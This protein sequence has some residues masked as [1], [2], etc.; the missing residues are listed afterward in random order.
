MEFAR[1]VRWPVEYCGTEALEPRHLLAGNPLITEFMASNGGVLADGDGQS[2]DWIEI[3]NAADRTIDLA[4]YRLTDT[5]RD[6]QR[7]VFPSVRLE[8][9]QYLV[10]FA[11]SQDTP[12]YLDAAGHLHTDF[13]LASDGEYVALVSPEGV[14]LSEYAADGQRYPPQ[15]TNVSYGVAQ[16]G[17]AVGAKVGYMVA[18]SPGGP[19]SQSPQVFS[20]FVVGTQFEIPHGLFDEP[21]QLAIT[22]DPPE[23]TIRYTTDGSIPTTDHGYLYEDPILVSGTTT[24]RAAAFQPDRIPS[25]VDT[26]TYIFPRDVLG[27][28]PRGEPPPGFPAGPVRTQQLDYGMDPDIVDDPIWGPLLIQALSDIPTISIVTDAAQLF[29]SRTG[30][31]V[32]AAADGPEWERPVSVELIRPDGV[33]GF[34]IDAGLR[35]RGGYSRAGI[36]PKHAFRLF[37]RNQYGGDLRYPLF[38]AEGVD[39]FEKIDLRTTQNY[40]WAF[41]GD[42]RNTFLR[43]VLS[44]D[45]QGEMGQPYTR[46]RYYHLYLNGQYWGLYQTQERSEA[47]YAASY[48]GGDEQDYDVIKVEASGE[49]RAV[50]TDGDMRA[51]ERLHQAAVRGF[52]D[53]AD[54]YR[55]QGLN[56][57]GTRDPQLERLLDADNLIDYMIVTY[58]TGDSDGP[59]SRFTR[60]APNNFFGVINRQAPDGFKWLEHDSE[61]SFNT[62]QRNMVR[63]LVTEDP[64]FD[65]ARLE[66]FNP[67]WLHEVLMQ[68]AEYALHFADRVQYHFFHDGAL[69]EARVLDLLDQRAR[70]IRW[71]IV[72]ESAR[73]G[74]AQREPALTQD[75]WLHAVEAVRQF[76]TGSSGPRTAEVIGQLRETGYFPTLDAP[77]VQPYGGVAGPSLAVALSA[78]AG[79]V[80]YTTDGSDPRLP[81]GGISTAATLYVGPLAWGNWAGTISAGPATGP[82]VGAGSGP[83]PAAIRP[84]FAHH[85]DQLPPPR[86]TWPPAWTS[87][88]RRRTGSSSS[89][90]PMPAASRSSWRAFV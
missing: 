23:A 78:T 36:N 35:I 58:Y 88:T 84:A 47:F 30:I 90:W 6:L 18:P 16:D 38:G 13:A 63:P 77:D 87:R 8:P 76:I 31:Y 39:E 14:I 86:A 85:R 52:Q 34:Q 15:R 61:H 62:G 79:T 20:G 82:M 37:F 51:F 68:N 59:G 60:P 55:I 9:G 56:P 7:W 72:A 45:M 80:Y 64:G 32:N 49:R 24:V 50:A 29:D 21:F 17:S 4:G 1:T 22:A 19:N 53:N 27:Q 71:A 28:S 83:L 3:F 33:D 10:V 81:G 67:H 69:A 42:S 75:D 57:D 65:P 5:R 66:Y 74:D 44:R 48:L 89:S 12:D 46:S 70:E 54:Y 41:D 25:P 40:S 2:S 11:S 26:R 43:D 73:W